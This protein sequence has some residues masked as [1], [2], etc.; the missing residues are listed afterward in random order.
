M[1]RDL[2]NFDK[3]ALLADVMDVN[4][5]EVLSLDKADPNHSF[6]NVD[7]KINEIIDAHIPSKKLTKKDFKLQE[8]PWITSG[9]IKSIKRRDNLLRKYIDAKGTVHED[10][11]HKQ[12]KTLRNKIK[13][14]I[15]D[16]VEKATFKIILQKIPQ[17]LETH[18]KVLKA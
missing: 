17:I 7:K 18:G 4:W 5:P 8:K 16:I 11:I 12:Y 9:I 15:E 1:K 13:K 10:D 2:K 6:K 3:E 14:L